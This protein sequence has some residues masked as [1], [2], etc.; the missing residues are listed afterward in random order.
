M[1]KVI[2][3]IALSIFAT[4]TPTLASPVGYKGLD[5]Y[6][7]IN[8]LVKGRVYHISFEGM[9]L[10]RK[11]ISNKCGILELKPSKTDS[12]KVDKIEVYDEGSQKTYGFSLKNLPLRETK[13]CSG[14]VF[15]NHEAWISAKGYI[16][17]SGLTPESSQTIKFLSS[18]PIHNLKPNQCGFLKFRLDPSNTP[19][20]FIMEGLAYP[21][22]GTAGQGIYCKR[23]TLYVQYPP[24][25]PINPI[26]EATWR[27][28]NPIAQA[29]FSSGTLIP[30]IDSSGVHWGII[31]SSGSGGSATSSGGGT[32]GGGGSSTSSGGGGT[33][34]GGGS[35]SSSGGGG[36]TG[37][38]GGTTV[39]VTP[40]SGG[41]G[42]GGGSTPTQSK[43]Q[44]PAGQKM[45]KVG[46]Q[47]VSIVTKKNVLY[48]SATE[49]DQSYEEE[50]SDSTGYTIFNNIN[51]KDTS[52]NGGLSDIEIGEIDLTKPSWANRKPLGGRWTVNISVVKPCQ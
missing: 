38:G 45:C 46:T 33:T 50:N 39:A 29:S 14:Q 48:Y 5:G 9:S 42:S 34:G 47:L 36:T 28:Q 19:S 16:G 26:D 13:T 3:A 20:A 41:G 35:S 25:T 1:K 22:N 6:Y 44:P 17:I 2:V 37:G 32:T 12:N 49:E 15:S 51:F 4:S 21:T 7:F 43:P 24:P 30:S 11:A 8:K 10:T 23:G 31:T 27:Q 40:P 18:A 52:N